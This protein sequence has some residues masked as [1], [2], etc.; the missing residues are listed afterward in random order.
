MNTSHSFDGQFEF[1][2]RAK[3]WSL[4]MIVIGVVGLLVNFLTN[5]EREALQ[6]YCLTVITCHAYAFA[7]FS[8]APLQYVA[9]AGWS[10]AV[11]RVP[12]A[13]AKVLPYAGLILI[14]IICAGL[15]ITPPRLERGRQN[16]TN[17]I[18]V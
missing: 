18:L 11:L 16:D 13:L 14:A 1:K 7:V 17:A 5:G 3:T 8:F 15:F 2:G 4:I 10:T 9:Q 6:I 12:Q